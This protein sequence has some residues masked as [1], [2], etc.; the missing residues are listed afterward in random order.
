MSGAILVFVRIMC[1]ISTMNTTHIYTLAHPET[2]VIRYVGK[3]NKLGPRYALHLRKDEATVKSR[4]IQS[5]KKKGLA[6][7]MEVLD[8]VPVEDWQFWEMYWIA[9]LK[10]WGCTLYNGDNGG[11]GSDRLPDAVKSRIADTL[12]G[13]SMP[14][15]WVQYNQYALNGQLIASHESAKAAA[16]AV[17]GGHPN[18]VRSAKTGQQAYGF[19]WTN[20]KEPTAC[21][22]SRFNNSGHIPASA[23]TRAKIV[24]ANTG[25]IQPPCTAETRA[26]MRAARLGVA[27]A[28][29][30]I[31][32]T[33]AQKTVLRQASTTR[34][35]VVQLGIDGS[36]IKEWSS[37][38]VASDSTGIA[39]AGIANTIKGKAKHA[40]GFLWTLTIS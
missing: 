26:K 27:P 1:Y 9:Q 36:Y 32:Q 13:R 31:P 16:V 35:S 3:A 20:S 28:N 6:P 21:I 2:G 25:R 14:E 19:I 15:K 7:N 22:P 23:E 30:G 4:W 10:A 8:V 40:G 29:K 37:V 39:R 24:L 17:C 33:E 11:L 12:R 5:L 18:I 34:K 38:K